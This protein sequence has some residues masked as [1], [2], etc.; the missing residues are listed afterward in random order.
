MLTA[1]YG[2]ILLRLNWVASPIASPVVTIQQERKMTR[3]WLIDTDKE[4]NKSILTRCAE[5]SVFYY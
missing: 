1:W 5:L 4:A 3:I 2:F